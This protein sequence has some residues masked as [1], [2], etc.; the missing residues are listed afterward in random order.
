M[1]L[2]TACMEPATILREETI[3]MTVVS[4]KEINMSRGGDYWRLEFSGE[5]ASTSMS[6]HGH[7]NLDASVVGH[8]VDVKKSLDSDGRIDYTFQ[9]NYDEAQADIMMNYC[10]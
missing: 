5:R 8:K 10:W 6:I 4:M 2:L 7:C 9:P 1:F 3:P